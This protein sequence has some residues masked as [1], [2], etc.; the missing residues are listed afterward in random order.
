MPPIEGVERAARGRCAGIT[1]DANGAGG[2]MPMIATAGLRRAAGA[3]L[4]VAVAAAPAVGQELSEKSVRTFMEYAWS[5][6]PAK[7]TK[8]DGS[9]VEIDKKKKEQVLV[10]ID[11][12]RE[13]IRVGRLSA[14]AQVCELGE[15]Q[16]LNYR[17]LMKREHEKKKWTE[18][19][20]IYLNQLHLT[21]VMLLTGKIKL[22]EKDGDKEVVVE[23]SK[24]NAQTCSAEQRAKVKELI[25]VYVSTGPKLAMPAAVPPPATASAPAPEKK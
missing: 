25:M 18:Q 16:V 21:T 2:E 4:A 10:P 24:S 1:I 9:V 14:H 23:E 19:Q 22:V 5:L 11:V 15:E 6:V 20:L 3:V 17:S 8:P 13:V 12:A 7:F